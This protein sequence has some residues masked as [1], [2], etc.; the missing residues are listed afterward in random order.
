MQN[1]F[2]VT[3]SHYYDW[4]QDEEGEY[5]AHSEE[6]YDIFGGVYTSVRA[7]AAAVA[8]F[9][10]N[11]T[12]DEDENEGPIANIKVR[13]AGLEQDLTSG[14]HCFEVPVTDDEDEIYNNLSAKLEEHEAR[15]AEFAKKS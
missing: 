3:T 15:M 5:E 2:I 6:A 1:L 12:P 10:S 7:V 8:K 11:F 4:S 13:L 14:G 9:V